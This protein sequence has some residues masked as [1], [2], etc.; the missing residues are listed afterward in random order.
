MA[1]LARNFGTRKIFRKFCVC[2]Y[3]QN[4]KFILV[5]EANEIILDGQSMIKNKAELIK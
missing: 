1:N 5:K 3:F 2:K 4:E